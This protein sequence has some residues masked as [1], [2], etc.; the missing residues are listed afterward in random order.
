MIVEKF[1]KCVISLRDKCKWYSQMCSI[2]SNNLPILDADNNLEKCKLGKILVLVPHADDEWIGTSQVLMNNKDVEI[3]Y[4]EF[5][6]SNYKKENKLVRN[7]ELQMLCNKFNVKINTSEG[8]HSH[9]DALIGLLSNNTY[10]TIFVPAFNDWHN[11]HREANYI[12][13]KV[14]DNNED[15]RFKELYVYQ[16][17]V[18]HS[19]RGQL[20]YYPMKKKEL[21]FKRLI[22]NEYY[23][24]QSNLPI[25]RFNIQ[26]CLNVRNVKTVYSGE[27]Y[28][29][30]KYKEWRLCLEKLDEY[31]DHIFSMYKSSINDVRKIRLLSNMY[32]V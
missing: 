22:F 14:F 18:P 17:S 7:V 28:R 6:G 4:F 20:F 26:D 15:L 12:L 16:I 19:N 32:D 13:K 24:S 2:K 30:V 31:E 5:F 3:Y 11:E 23:K 25:L 27:L 9:E 21:M 1:K 29:V 8:Y 10:E